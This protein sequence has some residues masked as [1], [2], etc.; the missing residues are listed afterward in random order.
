MKEIY[1]VIQV[2]RVAATKEA[3]GRRGIYALNA[4]PALGHGRGYGEEE[5]VLA[6]AAVGCEEAVAALSTLPHL[7]PKRS[8]SVMVPDSKVNSAVEAIIEANRTGHSGDGKIFVCPIEEAIRIRTGEA[9]AVT[10][11]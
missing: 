2:G 1:A 5:E 4:F 8:L 9:G 10:L 11:E 6:G 7:V 3:L